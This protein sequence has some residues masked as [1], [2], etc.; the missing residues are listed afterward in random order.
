MTGSQHSPIVRTLRNFGGLGSGLILSRLIKFVAIVLLARRLG[1]SSYGHLAFGLVLL[2]YL[3]QLVNLAA[4]AIGVQAVVENRNETGRII[5]AYTAARLATGL[6]VVAA[7]F[8]LGD[9]LFDPLDAALLSTLSIALIFHGL[10]PRWAYLALERTSW[11]SAAGVAGQVVLLLIVIFKVHS[12]GD[13]QNAAIAWVAAA[14][15]TAVL[16]Q[17]ALPLQRIRLRFERVAEALA[18]YARRSGEVV[19]VQLSALL[20]FNTDLVLLGLMLG[21]TAVG[22]FSAAATMFGFLASLTMAF[23]SG[24]LPV[25]TGQRSDNEAFRETATQALRFNLTFML[26]AAIGGAL[27]SGAFLSTVFGKEYL[28]GV[29]VMQLLALTLPL[30]SHRSILRTALYAQGRERVVMKINLAGMAINFLLDL[31]LIPIWGIEGAAVATF[32]IVSLLTLFTARATRAIMPDFRLRP[33]LI[34]LLPALV[35]MVAFLLW[36]PWQGNLWLQIA[37]AAAIYLTVLAL[38]ARSWLLGSTRAQTSR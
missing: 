5:G 28:E 17:L 6:L 22:Q 37:F 33:G 9:K 13:L 14:A 16:L 10:D 3:E 24:L 32:V 26:P 15:T 18:K 29:F 23:A 25:L 1:V 7:I 36:N 30:S 27:L 4:D 19:L 12:A 20:L 34:R 38:T 31:F 2:T 21:P 11:A 8:L 35:A